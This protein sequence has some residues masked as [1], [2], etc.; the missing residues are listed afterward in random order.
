MVRV[1]NKSQE[2]SEI[3]KINPATELVRRL[4]IGQVTQRKIPGRR[5]QEESSLF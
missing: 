2:E 5:E 4:L 3:I 1:N